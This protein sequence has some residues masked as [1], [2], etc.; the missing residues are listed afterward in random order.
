MSL[1]LIFIYAICGIYL[2]LNFK[3]DIHMLQQNSYR[4]E[5]YWRWLEQGNF[6]TAWRLVDIALIF[7]L[8]STLLTPALCVLL[9][10]IVCLIKCWPLLTA[11]HKKPLVF[12]RRVWRI[13]GVTTILGIIPY[14]LMIIFFGGR[15]DKLDFYNG[16][17]ATLA[18][19]LLTTTLSW[20][21]VIAAV[22]LLR[23][24]EAHINKGYWNDARRIL[25]SMPDLK[26]IGITGSYGKTSTKH[27][28]QSILSE[29]YETLMTPG[30]YNTPMG[31][32]RTVRE[33]MKPYTEV[34]ICEMGAKQKGDIKEICDLVDPQCGIITAVGPMHL[35][36]FGTIDNVCATKFELADAIPSE[37]FVV[38]NNDFS[39]AAGRKVSNTQAIRYGVSH[40]E[41][42]QFVAEEVKYSPEGSTFVMVSPE[43][44]RMQ[45][46]TKLVG[47]ANISNL[48]AAIIVA[49]QLGMDEETIRRGV[50]RIEQVEHRLNIKRTP[51]GVTI[52]DDAFNSNPDGSKMALEVL[53][54]FDTGRRIC[55]TPGMIELGDRRE[56]LNE[57]LGQHI[58]H[59][60]DIAIIVNAYNR[61]SLVKGVLSTGFDKENLH[62]V[63][64]FAAA[65]QLLSKILRSGDVILY[66]NDLPDSIK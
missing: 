61:D 17:E 26:I 45:F 7:L 31:V 37:G 66:E 5:R 23:P 18:V 14:A 10:A 47:E 55:V 16:P 2:L 4:I 38:I 42:C 34:F 22:W 40:P 50:N 29:R 54:K 65:Q 19:M 35:E 60:S 8:L 3:R 41:G 57:Q 56:E 32:I 44:K 11:K 49:L 51:G 53:G 46:S 39:P 24:V 59:N 48:M 20:A 15:D 25:K 1:F 33:M 64:D 58:G 43:G 52:I 63:H 13:Y 12:T 62:V 36:T 9:T 30:S 21:F 6:I 28:L 27:Y